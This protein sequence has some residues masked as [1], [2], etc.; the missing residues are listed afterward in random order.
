M[1][2]EDPEVLDNE[3]DETDASDEESERIVSIT[4]LND[5]VDKLADAVAGLAKGGTKT[6]T[7]TDDAEAVRTQVR[8]EVARMR[9]AEKQERADKGLAAKVSALEKKITEKA[10]VEY[11]KITKMIWGDPSDG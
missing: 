4:A 8:D 3:E 7:K 5:K 10:P 1:A 9:T 6:A 11:R 2:D